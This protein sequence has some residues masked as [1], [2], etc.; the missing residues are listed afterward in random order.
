MT[1]DDEPRTSPA[2]EEPAAVSTRE[3]ILDVALERFIR[4]GYAGTSL[5]E[6]AED[7]GFSK[8][9][10]YYHYASKE[11]IFLALHLRVH[12]LMTEAAAAVLLPDTGSL[13]DEA[14]AHLVEELIGIA[15]RNRSLLALHLREQDV[16][17][18]LH[19]P[20][21]IGKHGDVGQGFEDRVA[22][23]LRDTTAD[24]ETRIRRLAALGS[25]VAALFGA[26]V[27]EGIDDDTIARVLRK[28]SGQVLSTRS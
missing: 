8:A 6:I 4:Q 18:A 16:V 21:M 22:V 15:I 25:V 17:A 1:N 11:D 20:E 9:A 14:F 7:L 3:R 27:L 24:P 12:H 19:R 5:R 10:L 28:V 26:G 13:D 2:T 23:L